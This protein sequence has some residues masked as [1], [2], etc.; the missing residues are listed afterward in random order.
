MLRIGI[1][2]EAHSDKV[3]YQLATQGWSQFTKDLS[4]ADESNL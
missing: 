3:V 2:K 1:N 4:A